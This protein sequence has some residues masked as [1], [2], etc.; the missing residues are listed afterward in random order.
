MDVKKTQYWKNKKNR[1]TGC[2]FQICRTLSFANCCSSF[3]CFLVGFF[4]P[5]ELTKSNLDSVEGWCAASNLIGALQNWPKKNKKT[6]YLCTVQQASSTWRMMYLNRDMDGGPF[7]V[8]FLPIRG[9]RRPL[10][11][12]LFPSHS[13]WPETCSVRFSRGM[14]AR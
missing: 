2:S 7:L 1:K 14:I 11:Y 10:I 4:F 3:V 6:H 5:E 9:G 8:Y 13:W 12:V